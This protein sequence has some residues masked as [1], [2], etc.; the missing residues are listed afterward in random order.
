DF[1]SFVFD[2]GAALV[3]VKFLD[4]FQFLDDD[5]AQLRLGSENRFVLGNGFAHLLQLVRN[6]VDREL[7]QP[8]QLQFE[9]GVGLLGG[10]RLLGGKLR[11]ASGG[12]DVN[13]LAAEVSDQIL[14]SVGA[15][16]TAANDHDDVIKVIKRGE[17]AFQNMLAIARLIQ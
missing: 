14:A 13:L 17:V 5:F 4:L 15:V 6:F 9:D 7:G 1:R 3:A 16:C 8:V 10:K 11:S 12:V 2:H